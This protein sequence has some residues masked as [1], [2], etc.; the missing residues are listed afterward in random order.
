M[1]CASLA[2]SAGAIS[3][4]LGSASFAASSYDCSSAGDGRNVLYL[5]SCT[6]AQLLLSVRYA[7]RKWG[8]VPVDVPVALL[9]AEA[10]D[11]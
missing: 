1:I 5:R 2:S 10:Q 8:D 3:R 11:V 6:A 4:T 7:G 9:A